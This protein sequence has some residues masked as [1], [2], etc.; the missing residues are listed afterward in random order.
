MVIKK[1]LL[2]ELFASVETPEDLMGE[3]GLFKE[4]TVSSRM[5]TFPLGDP[6]FSWQDLC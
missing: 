5:I 4:L 2:D 6:P 3:D 1:E